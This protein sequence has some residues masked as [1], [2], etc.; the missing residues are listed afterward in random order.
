ML[1]LPDLPD[2]EL[3]S[4]LHFL[5]LWD[6]LQL[7]KLN[8]QRIDL[9]WPTPA[10]TR[11]DDDAVKKVQDTILGTVTPN[12][13]QLVVNNAEGDDELMLVLPKLRLWDLFRLKQSCKRF[14]VL[15]AW[16]LR[17]RRRIDF[18]L[19]FR[20]SPERYADF[21]K[22]F[23]NLILDTVGANLE[24]LKVGILYGVF[25]DRT[26][27]A[28]LAGRCPKLGYLPIE[29][30]EV[31]SKYCESN[32]KF[33]EKLQLVFENH[34]TDRKQA[35]FRKNILSMCSNLKSLNLFVDDGKSIS[36]ARDILVD[37]TNCLESLTISYESLTPQLPEEI[38]AI[39]KSSSMLDKITLNVSA[40]V[41]SDVIQ[42]TANLAESLPK[43]NELNVRS[44]SDNL[45]A[46]G[47]YITGLE[48]FI[49]DDDFQL[50]FLDAFAKLV[51]LDFLQFWGVKKLSQLVDALPKTVKYFSTN[52]V[53]GVQFI[54]LTN[55]IRQ[56]GNQLER[57]E[58]TF[59]GSQCAFHSK[60]FMV[61]V[62]T[63]CTGLKSLKI[64][65]L[66]CDFGPDC[67]EE[68]ELLMSKLENMRVLQIKGLSISLRA[69][70]LALFALR[71]LEKVEV[72]L[73]ESNH[74]KIHLT[75]LLDSH[76]N[77]YEAQI[78]SRNE[79]SLE[80]EDIIYRYLN[81]ILI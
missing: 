35:A 17:S 31:L 10:G 57:L 26:F 18:S 46:L 61:E 29:D 53:D 62:A 67:S 55:L 15:V 68:L 25:Q 20:H 54:P 22:S 36:E 23:R 24:E 40:P 30:M 8:Q 74:K 21:M 42:L 41:T 16:Y 43:L 6:I 72:T 14:S 9:S 59:S 70:E 5:P 79:Y 50:N 13:E 56:R 66:S 34:Y 80:C 27:V 32:G 3:M 11:L 38:Q 51:R 60:M 1:R 58:V 12:L 45:D 49:M 48:V 19:P 71:H 69:F 75:K 37:R 78:G 39:V 47:P 73:T 65:N 52:C 44:E 4:I 7:K 77:I 81:G 76:P 28:R 63:S 2:A 64:E 33:V